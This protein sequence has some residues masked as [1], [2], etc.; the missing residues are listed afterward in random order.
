MSRLLLQT[1]S[2]AP[3]PPAALPAS[4]ITKSGMVYTFAFIGASVLIGLCFLMVVF[5]YLVTYRHWRPPVTAPLQVSKMT[6]HAACRRHDAFCAF[7]T[8]WTF[9]IYP[10]TIPLWCTASPHCKLFINC[11]STP[12]LR[13]YLAF[14]QPG[15]R[16]EEYKP[17]HPHIKEIVMISNPDG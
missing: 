10:V 5:K 11:L 17:E 16:S 2:G 7:V 12:Y 6:S 13:L 4:G 14:V 8:A 3:A 1:I 9:F 15:R